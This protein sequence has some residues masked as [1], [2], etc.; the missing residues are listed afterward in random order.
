[1]SD[2]CSLLNKLQ[3]CELWRIQW[4]SLAC[5]CTAAAP[6]HALVTLNTANKV[7][8][9]LPKGS[10]VEVMSGPGLYVIATDAI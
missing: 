8:G 2:C 4:P 7:P 9:G 3:T 6:Q 10:S 5:R 1:M